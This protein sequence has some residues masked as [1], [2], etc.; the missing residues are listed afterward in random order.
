MRSLRPRTVAGRA[1]MYLIAVVLAV[2]LVP[3]AAFNPLV[4]PNISRT[5]RIASSPST[6]AATIGPP[7]INPSSAGYHSFF[8]CSA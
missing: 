6:T 3:A 1:G 7:V 5:M 2:A 8:T 4:A